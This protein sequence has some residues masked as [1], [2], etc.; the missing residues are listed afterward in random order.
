MTDPN[1]WAPPAGASPLPAPQLESPAPQLE[2]SATPL[3]PFAP[4]LASATPQAPP[5]PAT[6]AAPLAVGPAW[7]P[8]PRPGLIPLR[9]MTLGTLLAASFRVMRRNPK[10]TLGLALLLYLAI[11]VA[12]GAAIGSVVAWAIGR[13]SM[14]A[15][16]AQ[17]DIIAGSVLGGALSLLVPLVSSGLLLAILQGI[18]SLEVARGTLG[19]KLTTRELYRRARGRIGA[20]IGWSFAQTGVVTGLALLA[21]AVLVLIAVAGGAVGVLVA[22]GL[23]LL[24]GGLFLVGFAWIGTKVS[25]VPSALVLERLTLGRA[26]GRSW[27]LTGRGFWRTLG[28]EWLVQVIVSG[29]AQVISIPLSIIFSIGVGVLAPTGDVSATGG[30][31]IAYYA[32]TLA[33]ST[34]L[35]AVSVVMQSSVAALL[36]IDLRMRSEG[37]DIE[38]LH[39]VEARAAGIDAPDPY[40]LRSAA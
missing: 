23:G 20:L 19:E 5:P 16:E 3:A 21:V 13:I 33:L 27:R 22:V 10:P 31:F 7:T 6:A 32:V 25:L 37:L 2:S 11:V 15:G 29:A 26:I 8:P 1:G 4:P 14:S 40:A 35:G 34:V 30:A 9:P 28:T 12:S 18:V 24:I 39:A 36:Y 17:D 38:L